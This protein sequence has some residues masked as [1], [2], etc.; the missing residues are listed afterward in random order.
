MTLRILNFLTELYD[1]E[2]PRLATVDY[3]AVH[4]I[5]INKVAGFCGSP[6]ITP[7]TLLPNQRFD[8]PDHGADT[9]EGVVIEALDADG[10]T[11]IDLCA[12]PVANSTDA[13]TLL[14]RVSMIGLWAA[15]NPATYTFNY[16]LVVHRS[17]LAWLQA[18]CEGAAVVI[19][20][21]AARTFLE[22]ANMGGPIGAC[23]LAHQREL[24]GYL[25]NM[26]R[27]VE[28]VSPRSVRRAA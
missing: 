27:R 17:P 20:E 13:R 22:I 12:W 3:L 7:I 21:M 28:I 11:V 1:L 16:P 6:T 19:P 8:L 10:E 18:G 9:V 24:K 26:I 14:G 25:H 5:D 2:R 4:A 15:L 23:D